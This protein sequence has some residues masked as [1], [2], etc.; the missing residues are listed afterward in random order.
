MDNP[1]KDTR[2]SNCHKLVNKEERCWYSKRKREP[3][4][5]RYENPNRREGCH[6]GDPIGH[7]T[8]VMERAEEETE[9]VLR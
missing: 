8:V 6:S 4:E 2:C 7:A 3:T 9:A 5:L 1:Y